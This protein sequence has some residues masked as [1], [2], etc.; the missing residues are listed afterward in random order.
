MG[1]MFWSDKRSGGPP[2]RQSCCRPDRWLRCACRPA[3]FRCP[4]GAG[5]GRPRFPA[6][7]RWGFSRPAPTQLAKLCYFPPG[8]GGGV[9][10]SPLSRVGV[11][12]ACPAHN[13]Q[14]CATSLRGGEGASALPRFP[15]LGFSR[16][17]PHTTCKVVLLSSGAGRGHPRF[18]AFPRW[19]SCGRPH[20]QLAKLCYFPPGRTEVRAPGGGLSRCGYGMTFFRSDAGKESAGCWKYEE[21]GISE[22]VWASHLRNNCRRHRRHRPSARR[23]PISPG[24]RR[25]SAGSSRHAAATNSRCTRSARCWRRR[26]G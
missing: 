16:P 18:P 9:R 5:R 13:L 10:A 11:L 22:D 4:S 15:A 8:R 19:G 17:A 1:K 6:F 12:A 26:T 3:K 14:S 24:R 7:P 25:R 2:G 20:T 21:D 23:E